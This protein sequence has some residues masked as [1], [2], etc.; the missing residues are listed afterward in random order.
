MSF[1]LCRNNRRRCLIGCVSTSSRLHRLSCCSLDSKSRWEPRL[2]PSLFLHL[3]SFSCSSFVLCGRFCL[4]PAPACLPF[5]RHCP[6]LPT[7]CLLLPDLPALPALPFVYGVL[8]SSP[9]QSLVGCHSHQNHPIYGPTAST[10]PSHSLSS[11]LLS[12]S[13]TR[14]LVEQISGHLYS[15]RGV[16]CTSLSGASGP[17]TR[18]SSLHTPAIPIPS[19]ISARRSCL[20]ASALPLCLHDRPAPSPPAHAWRQQV[21]GACCF[22]LSLP[23]AASLPRSGPLCLPFSQSLSTLPLPR[24]S[25]AP[26]SL[27]SPFFFGLYFVL[28]LQFTSLLCPL[29]PFSLSGS[30]H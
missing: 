16:G 17:K 20:F 12:L 13:H 2:A 30:R 23:L 28:C 10:P 25:P 1:I 18:F 15:C 27:P 5:A 3:L 8:A 24:P 7:H 29:S 19:P 9:L 11:L 14:S 26:S 22:C 21:G 4:L 6:P